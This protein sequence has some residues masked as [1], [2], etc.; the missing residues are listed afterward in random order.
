MLQGLPIPT[1][2][3]HELALRW[4]LPVESVQKVWRDFMQVEPVS[5]RSPPGTLKRA[6]SVLGRAIHAQPHVA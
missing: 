4:F 1:A 2:I 3:L 5:P 6:A